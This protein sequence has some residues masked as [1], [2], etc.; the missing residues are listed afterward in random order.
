MLSKV[1]LFVQVIYISPKVR[2]GFAVAVHHVRLSAHAS[3]FF[4]GICGQCEA[5]DNSMRENACH[6]Y[7]FDNECTTLYSRRHYIMILYN[8]PLYV[9]YVVI[10]A[11]IYKTASGTVS[12]VEVASAWQYCTT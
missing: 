8:T 10:Q 12:A 3:L 1:F 2:D 5:L 4:W 7:S 9:S 6:S 11:R